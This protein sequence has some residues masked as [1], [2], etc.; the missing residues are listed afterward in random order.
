TFS[1]AYIEDV[2]AGV[3]DITHDLVALFVTRFDPSLSQEKRNSQANALR[4]KIKNSL[5]EVKNIDEDR[6]IRRYMQVILATIRTNFFQ[7]E[8][9]GNQKNYLSFKFDPSAI[10]ELPLPRPL[11]EIFV[12]SPRVEGVHLRGAKVA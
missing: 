8:A 11:Y 4:L 6:I 5:E 7:K 9:N 2:L 12:Y 1:Q 10:T 3:P